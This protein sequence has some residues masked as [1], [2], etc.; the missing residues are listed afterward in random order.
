MPIES[1]GPRRSPRSGEAH[2][3][4]PDS[5]APGEN[6]PEHVGARTVPDL[7]RLVNRQGQLV[8]RGYDERAGRAPWVSPCYYR[9]GAQAEARVSTAADEQAHRILPGGGGRGHLFD[10][11]VV[12][13]LAVRADWR[14][15]LG[16]RD[17]MH[18]TSALG[19]VTTYPL[20]EL[21]RRRGPA[22]S[23]A[24]AAAVFVIALSASD[25]RGVGSVLRTLGLATIVGLAVKN[26]SEINEIVAE[27]LLPQ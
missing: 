19:G 23:V 22:V 15:A 24:S 11:P 25:D 7:G 14:G 21:L 27:T 1:I 6:T 10:S 18:E 20:V 17:K 3:Q 8:I 26:L 4:P 9:A 13:V 16:A 5:H 2:G 12:Q